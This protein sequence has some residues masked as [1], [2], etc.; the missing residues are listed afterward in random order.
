MRD[1]DARTMQAVASAIRAGQYNLLLGSGVA[2]DSVNVLG[3][4]LPSTEK[5]RAD[6]CTLT[7]AKADSSLQRV[8]SS[9]HADQIKPNIIERFMVAK[10]GPSLTP[11]TTFLWRRIFTLNIDD[12]VETL[13]ESGRYAQRLISRNFSET[14]TESTE[15]TALDLIHLHGS[16]R[17]PEA[18]FV[19][20]LQAYAKQLTSI[21]PW[22]VLLTQFMPVEPFIIAGTSLS[23]SDVEYYLAQRSGTTTRAE[24]APSILVEPYPDAV[25]KIDCD[26]YGLILFEGTFNDLLQ[27]LDKEIPER[28]TPIELVPRKLRD[29]FAPK[30]PE[31][32]ALSFS[33]DFELV[34]NNA[35]PA[36]SPS[37]F[38]FG[39]PPSW[40]DLA[41]N[42]D[43]S[44]MITGEILRRL[45][46]QLTSPK[47]S[48]KVI[49][50]LEDPG[51]GKTTVLRRTAYELALRGYNVITCSAL[52]RLEPT[53]TADSLEWIDG[54][55]VIVVDNFADQS[56]AI[57][58]ILLRVRKRDIV[59]LGAERSYR[60]QYV[61][62]TIS[63]I[64][65][66]PIRGLT[67]QP[68]E[69]LRL[70]R[71][72]LDRGLIGNPAAKS[73]PERYAPLVARDE[74]AVAACRIL[75]DFRPL[76]SIIKSL[77]EAADT[78]ARQRFLSAALA[79]HCQQ[80]G[81]RY[82]ILLTLANP[83]GLDEQLQGP[84]PLPLSFSDS[85]RRDFVVPRSAAISRRLL[86]RV[87]QR[88]LLAIFIDLANAIS[89][90]VNPRTIRMRVPE[91]RLA[92]R[93]FDYDQI[94][95]VLLGDDF[96]A[97]FYRATKAA[98]QWNSRYWDQVALS[99]LTEYRTAASSEAKALALKEAIQHA[100]HAVSLEQH[101]LSLTTLAKILLVQLESG[102]NIAE[103]YDEAFQCLTLAINLEEIR[104][105][106]SVQP[107]IIL[108]RGTVVYIAQGGVL[109]NTQLD[110]LRNAAS[111]AQVSFDDPSLNDTMAELKLLLG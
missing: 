79:Y 14:Y 63:P 17:E 103:V 109:S 39:Q 16:V 26:R 101:P 56:N 58:D 3:H 27:Y 34:P 111:R 93:L 97:K 64:P 69:A 43:I 6:L 110:G 61:E 25:T 19:F 99:K 75:N 74:I 24:R 50:L 21:N 9:L 13:Y 15:P 29:L 91:A 52:S 4:N 100:R 44:R 86:E 47:P 82:S 88:E 5:L 102:L 66:E 77:L 73:A 90:R 80:G 92:S 20:S 32:M 11:L 76:D 7:G 84:H 35:P 23:E 83:T 30:I 8:F 96:A 41:G 46:I 22:M 57:S 89:A 67:L 55:L 38:L 1:F 2:L 94:V 108:F 95:R 31:H 60:Q 71:L 106:T 98:W 33:A 105:R 53:I 81:L 85:S 78:N 18:G 87:P 59:V 62:Q 37:P 12:A 72:Y 68:A 45:E 10:A 107:F 48:H 36:D 28:P 54:P 51:A 70:I 65:I 49:M 104:H 42:I 40:S